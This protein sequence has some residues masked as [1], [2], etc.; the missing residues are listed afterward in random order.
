MADGVPGIWL[1]AVDFGDADV[2][3]QAKPSRLL[4]KC[5]Y[6]L[7]K[8]NIPLSDTMSILYCIT[9]VLRNDLNGSMR[10]SLPMS[11]G[12]WQLL[13]ALPCCYFVAHLIPPRWTWENGV[14]ENTQVAVLVWGGVHAAAVWYRHGIQGDASLARCALPVWLMLAGREL[15]W[16]AVFLPPA[17]FGEQGTWYSSHYLW[18]RPAVT[19]VL[20]V[21]LAWTLWSAYRGRLDRIVFES[22]GATH[23]PWIEMSVVIG[24]A[25]CST[26]AE[27]ASSALLMPSTA[28]C[29]EE[30]TELLGYVALVMLQSSMLRSCHG[31]TAG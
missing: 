21:L 22:I 16:G 14:V 30:L 24:A 13:L 10:I 31:Y 9:R 20:I 23:M 25:I 19:P 4:H 15:S 18:Y 1:T 28:Q 29:L 5:S 26:L 7:K 27:Q 3:V 17:G 11:L 12:R 2:N 6:L 8:C